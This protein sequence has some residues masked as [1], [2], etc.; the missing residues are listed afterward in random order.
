MV[1]YWSGDI[2]SSLQLIIQTQAQADLMLWLTSSAILGYM[3]YWK[4]RS[5]LFLNLSL[6][7]FGSL[8]AKIVA[9]FASGK[10]GFARIRV[11]FCIS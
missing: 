11:S 4:W 9:N 10:P 3:E 6:L 2:L 8:L 5:A 1:F 7:A